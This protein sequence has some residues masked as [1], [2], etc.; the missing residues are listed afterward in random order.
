VAEVLR[1]TVKPGAR[2]AS[3]TRREDGTWLASV[4]AR[5]VE[6]AANEALLRL[7]ADHFGLPRSRVSLRTGHRA[8]IKTVVVSDP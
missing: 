1:I 7:V 4:R 2:V 6:G 8:R 5:P 3:L